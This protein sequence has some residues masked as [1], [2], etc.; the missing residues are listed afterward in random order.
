MTY[1]T[2]E[3]I[4][5]LD[6]ELAAACRGERIILSSAKRLGNPVIAKALDL[7]QVGKV[8]AYQD[9][10]RQI[11]DYQRERGVS[12]VVWRACHFRGQTVQVPEVHN[13]LLPIPG[14]KEILI[15]AKEALVNF[16]QANSADLKQWFLAHRPRPLS[17]E[18]WRTVTQEGEWAELE[19]TQTELFLRL[20][21]G[22]PQ[23]ASFPRAWPESGCYRLVAAPG[24]P[25][26]L[27]F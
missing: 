4:A 12:G 20:C 10:R 2:Q 7:D 26:D 27:R 19:A 6:R 14:D 3:L 9:F 11:H 16:W 25:S 1:T 5:I 22:D 23:E 17:A 18:T 15:G 24:E 21:W 8:F 13:Q